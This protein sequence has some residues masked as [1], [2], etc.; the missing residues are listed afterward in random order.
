M[1]EIALVLAPIFL[2]ILLGYGLRHG[3]SFPGSFWEPAERLTYYA[4]FPALLVTST[5]STH[6]TGLDAAPMAMAVV[7]ALLAQ[8]GAVLAARPFTGLD[9][10]AF[11]SV[12]QGA[13]RPNIY[14][15]IAT[16]AAVYGASGLALV[17]IPIALT[18]PLVN[19]MSVVVLARLG[20]DSRGQRTV[21]ILIEVARNPLIL[22]CLIG[23]GLNVTDVGLPP[24]LGPLLEIMGR[25]ALPLGLMAVGAALDLGAAR[26][27]GRVVAITSLLKLV[28]MPLATFAACAMFGAED[29]ATAVAVLFSGG[30]VA[31]ASY[32][33]ARRMGGDA[34]L[35][36]GLITASTLAAMVTLPLVATLMAGTIGR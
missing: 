12:F 1:I 3:G 36:A 28:G 15:A 10:P 20:H 34:P 9:G 26:R 31:V 16:V 24:V 4:L 6:L 14:V 5:A 7:A 27:A 23:W 30:P 17:S 13:I 21:W 8:A 33:L 29:K 22:A 11:T 32:V 19:I 35:L 2:L 25:A 18:V